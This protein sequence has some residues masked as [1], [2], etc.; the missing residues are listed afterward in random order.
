MET[1]NILVW[2][3]EIRKI[4][5]GKQPE[6]LRGQFEA[7]K[8]HVVS[9]A[10]ST[11]AALKFSETK[12]L[13]TEIA[14]RSDAAILVTSKQFAVGEQPSVLRLYSGGLPYA[15][16]LSQMATASLLGGAHVWGTDGDADETET[17]T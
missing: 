17:V 15:I 6:L 13:F 2:L 7:V 10:S 14:A 1:E 3:D 12:D 9:L 4:L 11:E 8:A 16:G 5:P